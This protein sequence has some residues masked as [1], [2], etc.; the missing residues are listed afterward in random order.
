[1]CMHVY[2]RHIDIFQ[3]AVWDHIVLTRAMV[4]NSSKSGRHYTCQWNGELPLEAE[5]LLEQHASLNGLNKLQPAA[6]Y[7]N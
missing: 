4:T 2:V 7:V 6:M 3:M 1:M 5:M